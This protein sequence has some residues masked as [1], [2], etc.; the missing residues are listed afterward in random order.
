V[1]VDGFPLRPANTLEMEAR[2][3][4]FRTTPC[5]SPNPPTD[6]YEDMVGVDAIA[7][8]PVPAD[9]LPLA[10]IYEGWPPTLDAGGQQTLVA[11]PGPLK[12]YLTFAVLG[13]AYGKE[14]MAEAPEIAAHCKGRAA[15]YEALFTQYYGAGT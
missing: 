11:A 15:M 13:E 6:W 8:A 10:R 14:G 1:S 5:I 3:D 12:G 9:E 4:G 2:D 7:F